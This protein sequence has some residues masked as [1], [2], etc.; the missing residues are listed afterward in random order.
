MSTKQISNVNDMVTYTNSFFNSVSKTTKSIITIMVEL[1][2]LTAIIGFATAHNTTAMCIL[3]LAGIGIIMNAFTIKSYNEDYAEFQKLC[4]SFANKYTRRDTDV[5]VDEVK[6]AIHEIRTASEGYMTKYKIISIAN[7][8]TLV[9]VAI[10]LC[11]ILTAV[12]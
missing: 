6:Y 11:L 1:G 7:T 5:S 4:N 9:V 12:I 2:I 3:F 10:L 8:I